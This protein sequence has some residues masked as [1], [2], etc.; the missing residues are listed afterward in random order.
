[1]L[2]LGF[3]GSNSTKQYLIVLIANHDMR[4]FNLLTGWDGPPFSGFLIG[5][6]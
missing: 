2:Y 4:V 6:C 3:W 1:M 5:E